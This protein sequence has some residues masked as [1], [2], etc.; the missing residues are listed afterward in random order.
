M[1][2]QIKFSAN[3]VIALYRTFDKVTC[4]KYLINPAML[5]EPEVSW[6]NQEMERMKEEEENETQDIG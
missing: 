3:F 6:V 4:E 5:Q 1:K 2:D